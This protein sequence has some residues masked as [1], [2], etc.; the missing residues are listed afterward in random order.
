[1]DEMNNVTQSVDETAYRRGYM[2]GYQAAIWAMSDGFTQRQ[3]SAFLNSQIYCWRFDMPIQNQV[4]PP[5]LMPPAG[6]RKP[7]KTRHNAL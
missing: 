2:Q 3:L 6:K 7:P 4:R 1:M 5:V